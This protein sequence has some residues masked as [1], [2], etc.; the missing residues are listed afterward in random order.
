MEIILKDGVKF[1]RHS[2]ETENQFEKIVFGQFKSIFGDNAILFDKQKIRTATGI[3]AIPDAFVI[4]PDK[5]KWYII[6][7]ELASHS[8]YEHIIPQIT[9][10]KNA[11]DNIQTRKTLSKYFDKAIEDDLSKLASWVSATDDKNVFRLL[12]EILDEEP[13]LL[14]IIDDT[15][16][17]LEIASKNLP[18]ATSINI[19]KT[20]SRE[21]Y[22]LGDNIF[23]FNTFN[24][25]KKHKQTTEKLSEPRPINGKPEREPWSKAPSPSA[26]EWVQSIPELSNIKGLYKWTDICDHYKLN[27]KGNSARRVLQK[28]VERNKPKWTPVPDA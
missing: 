5:K 28:W 18:F 3:G 23:Q 19:F 26:K 8:V 20:F 21:G 25:T 13:Q 16:E 12:S 9:K 27:H 6:E 1:T 11:L 14:I 4:S 10:F 24:E 17:E 7:V 15:N 22:G 2:F